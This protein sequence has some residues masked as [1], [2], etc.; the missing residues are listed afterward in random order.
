MTF[1][2]SFTEQ[3]VLNEAL[4]SPNHRYWYERVERAKSLQTPSC[5]KLQFL[6]DI[7]Y[8]QNNLE[9]YLTTFMKFVRYIF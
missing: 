1:I 9:Y 8:Q 3:N 6:G 5:E 7:L 4:N 2:D